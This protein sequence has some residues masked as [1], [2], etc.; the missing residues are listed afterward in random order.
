M[1]LNECDSNTSVPTTRGKT[2]QAGQREHQR[3]VTRTTRCGGRPPVPLPTHPRPFYSLTNSCRRRSHPDSGEPGTE[4]RECA[5]LSSAKPWESAAT[6]PAAKTRGK[7][8]QARHRRL[9]GAGGGASMAPPNP[10]TGTLWPASTV[11]RVTCTAEQDCILDT[12]PHNR[13]PVGSLP[14]TL[15][16]TRPEVPPLAV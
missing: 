6:A 5:S 3:R 11:A 15:G 13:S 16:S 12:G 8:P 14:E 9:R 2:L 10:R 4:T 7:G 1:T